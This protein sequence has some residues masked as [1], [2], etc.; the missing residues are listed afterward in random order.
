LK[1]LIKKGK[2]PENLSLG[3]TGIPKVR[4]DEVLIKV[5]AGAICGSDIH[6]MHDRYASTIPVVM[7]HEF[8]GVIEEVGARVNGWGKGDPVIAEGNIETCGTCFYC[9]TGISHV[10]RD[11]KFLGINVDGCFAE[12]VKIPARLLHQ[13]PEGLSF[14]EASL[15]EPSAVGIHALTEDNHVEV[16]DFV[17]ILGIGPIGLLAAQTARA[18]GA[19][20]I[21]ITG[22]EPDVPVRFK[23]ANDLAVCDY[24][25]NADKE[26]PV[27]VVREAT[28]GRGADL[29]LDTT[30]SSHGIEQGIEMVRRKGVFAAIGIGAEVV[31]V[32]WNRLINEVIRIQFCRS[33]TYSTFEKFCSLIALGQLNLKPL[34]TQQYPLKEWER[35]FQSLEKRESVKT[36]LIP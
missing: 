24:I 18:V 15:A 11:K 16:G 28:G 22:I 9:K 23:A 35:G 36:L 8:S 30:G 14:E 13:M 12:Y 5:K 20:K 31:K 10:C 3:E 1:A 25:V 19:G 32:P 2:G 6:V 26:D 27:K 7:G 21:V 33:Y 4:E 34:I 17:V 29:V